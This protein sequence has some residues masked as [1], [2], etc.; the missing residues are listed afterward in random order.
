MS[1]MTCMSCMSQ[2]LCTS[3]TIIADPHCPSCCPANAAKSAGITLVSIGVGSSVDDAFLR[4]LAS[5]SPPLYYKSP[6]FTSLSGLTTSILQSACT[7]ITVQK[8]GSTTPKV[9]NTNYDFNVTVSSVAEYDADNV[10]MLDTL[11]ANLNLV[12]ATGGRTG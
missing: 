12:S 3:I 5:G 6:T 11:P 2:P 4:T 9:I 8:T 10:V 1:C 7:S